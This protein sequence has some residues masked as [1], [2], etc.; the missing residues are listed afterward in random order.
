MK[1]ISKRFFSL[2]E[3]L[4]VIVIISILMGI[5]LPVVSSVRQNAKKAK[6]KSECNAI[7]TA[8]KSYE[9]TYGYL[10]LTSTYTPTDEDEYRQFIEMLTGYD[11][12]DSNTQINGGTY[13]NPRNIR[14]LDVPGT[15]GTDT[16]SR[17]LPS[18]A[19]A[20]GKMGDYVDPWGS[21]YMVYIDNDYDGQVTVNGKVL[22]GTVF[23][24]SLGPDYE[25]DTTG[26]YGTGVNKDNVC[27]WK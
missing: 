18:N 12:P 19:D 26:N 7:L 17:N 21:R 6:A 10:P 16:T 23:I 3:L 24:Y 25:H 14:F 27:S 2:I 8:I 9:S 5:L 11:G 22:N 13:G 15:Y 4:V 20:E 1:K